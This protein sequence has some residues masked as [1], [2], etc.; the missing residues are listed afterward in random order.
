M[1]KKAAL[2]LIAIASLTITNVYATDSAF[3]DPEGRAMTHINK[4]LTIQ[5]A[6]QSSI[7]AR[8]VDEF[9]FENRMFS[10]VHEATFYLTSKT[11]FSGGSRSDA[12]KGRKVHIIYHFEGDR[13]VSDTITAVH[14][15]R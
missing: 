15:Y 5:H 2:I 7:R 8:W 4:T 1:F 13:A 10:F 12:V 9:T 11:A 3:L 6:D 14:N